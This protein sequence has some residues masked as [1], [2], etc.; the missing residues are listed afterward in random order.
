V[1]RGGGNAVAGRVALGNHC[2]AFE[3]TDTGRVAGW[4][5]GDRVRVLSGPFEGFTGTIEN[6][7]NDDGEVVVLV[8]IFGSVTPVWHRV[9]ELEPD[10][11]I[12]RLGGPSFF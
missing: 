8:Q 9:D 5:D 12:A 2:P 1:C 11:G 4:V 3:I 6:A 7:E 10:D